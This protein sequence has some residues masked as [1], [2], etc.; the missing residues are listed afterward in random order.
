MTI[1]TSILASHEIAAEHA[2]AIISGSSRK[3]RK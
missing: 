3:S 2:A 1:P